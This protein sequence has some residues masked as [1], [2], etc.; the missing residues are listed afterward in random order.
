MATD[1]NQPAQKL[2]QLQERVKQLQ[3]DAELSEIER[4]VSDITTEVRRL[5]QELAR[6]RHRGYVYARDLEQ[7]V[8]SIRGQWLN[9][10]PNLQNEIKAEARHLRTDVMQ[11]VAL[12]GAASAQANNVLGLLKTMPTFE[13]EIDDLEAKIKAAE[14]RLKNRFSAQ[15]RDV[16]QIIEEMD[17]IHA[18]LDLCQEASFTFEDPENVYLA[19]Q[20]EWVATGKGGDDPDGVL[21]LTDKRLI[22]EQKEKTG[23]KLGLFGGQMTHELKWQ[24]SL[25]QI[26][27]VEPEN[28]GLFGGK[29]LLHLTLG[30]GAPYPKITVEVKGKAK[31]KAWAEHIQRMMR[32]EMENERIG[33]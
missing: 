27:S 32:G 6:L 5:A 15:E 1:Q 24:L 12:S 26:V 28:K 14:S 2:A 11:V 18:L 21:F 30:A 16:S 9:E 29:D 31:S 13:K 17:D 3:A 33:R 10:L 25:S 19:A 22:F 4:D 8:E 7:R 20:G 23:K